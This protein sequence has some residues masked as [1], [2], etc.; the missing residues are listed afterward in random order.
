MVN[1]M[2]R[3]PLPNLYCDLSCKCLRMV[4]EGALDRWGGGGVMSQAEF[5]K[6]NI[7]LTN[8]RLASVIISFENRY[9][10]CHKCSKTHVACHLN[11]IHTKRFLSP[12]ATDGRRF[13]N[14]RQKSFGV[15]NHRFL[16]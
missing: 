16:K 12:T 6:G 2:E 5:K 13:K 9:V 10:P 11:L 1:K 14:R 4:L 8:L 15:N 7:A 3:S